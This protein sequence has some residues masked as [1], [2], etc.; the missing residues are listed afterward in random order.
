MSNGIKLMHCWKQTNLC[1]VAVHR[2]WVLWLSFVWNIWIWM[3]MLKHRFITVC[4]LCYCNKKLFQSCPSLRR[5][6]V[7]SLCFCGNTLSFQKHASQVNWI[8]WIALWHEVTWSVSIC[9]GSLIGWWP[10]QDDMLHNTE[11][12]PREAVSLISAVLILFSQENQS[13]GNRKELML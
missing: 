4:P 6:S 12:I 13:K 11:C 2:L 10:I 1:Q 3:K 5:V 9:V 8:L 7:V